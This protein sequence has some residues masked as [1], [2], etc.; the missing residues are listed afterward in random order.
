M[1]SPRTLQQHDG[2]GCPAGYRDLTQRGDGAEAHTPTS[3]NHTER[4]SGARNELG[5]WKLLDMGLNL[6]STTL[7]LWDLEQVISLS[8]SPGCTL[9]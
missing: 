5:A 1:E 6:S 7:Q 4:M 8:Q 2:I 9:E 3:P